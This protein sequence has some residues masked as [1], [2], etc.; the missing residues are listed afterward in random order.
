MKNMT[1][2]T[3]KQKQYSSPLYKIRKGKEKQPFKYKLPW[4]LLG[5]AIILAVTLRLVIPW[6]LAFPNEDWI[7]FGDVD[8]YYQMRVVDNLIANFPHLSEYDPYRTYPYQMHMADR[9]LFN[10]LIA[11]VAMILG[12]GNPSE[13]LVDLVGVFISPILFIF[14]IVLVFFIA[15]YL[16]NSWVAGISALMVGTLGGEI[17]GRS[18]LGAADHHTL[19]L[20]LSLLVIFL[21]VATLKHS[22]DTLKGQL[23]GVLAGLTLGFYYVAWSGALIVYM[24]IV[25]YSVTHIIYNYFKGL[26]SRDIML[27]STYP[28]LISLSI[29]MF[30]GSYSVYKLLM[31]IVCLI[32][33]VA[34]G[35][36]K[37]IK[38][39]WLYVATLI[40]AP[41]LFF[42]SF[43]IIKWYLV[44]QGLNTEFN[45]DLLIVRIHNYMED[46]AI[47]L[48]QNTRLDRLFIWDWPTVTEEE[49]PFLIVQGQ[50]SF[51]RVWSYFG[52]SFFIAVAMLVILLINAL[53]KGD[54]AKWFVVIWSLAMFMATLTMVR[55]AYYFAINVAIL[56]GWFCYEV[57]QLASPKLAGAKNALGRFII[58]GVVVVGVL[59]PNL[60][61]L[62]NMNKGNIATMRSGWHEAMLW[63]KENGEDPFGDKEFYYSLYDTYTEPKHSTMVWWDYGYWV[64]REG[65][66][67]ALA[68]PG[69]STRNKVAK[70]F[71]SDNATEIAEFMAQYKVKYIVVDYEITAHKF[72]ALPLLAKSEK[73][74]LNYY[75][76]FKVLKKVPDTYESKMIFYPD[77]Y[78]TLLNRLYYFNGKTIDPKKYPI[79]T[80]KNNE[81]I[82][83]TVFETENDAQKYLRESGGF[84]ASNNP[85]ISPIELPYIGN[86]KLVFESKQ[87]VAAT[88]TPLVKIFE[89]IEPDYSGCNCK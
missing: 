79:F 64:M 50:L 59:L 29:V 38:N 69:E 49:L 75:E 58:I 25:A 57:Y 39:K 14:V 24:I 2:P 23:F 85:S 55:F 13:R 9:P 46:I 8:C 86:F 22:M 12:G 18:M 42:A 44:S 43:G 83:V 28:M 51:A 66:Q 7:R 16:F 3:N 5:L 89:Y 61:S 70:C 37:I 6:D 62:Q 87:K 40:S 1:Y 48:G 80:A 32:P 19:E 47:F 81:L 63:L 76:P 15:L 74:I 77:Y 36:S 84:L 31:L 73:N 88:G 35:L 72:Y 41:I 53:K 54:K 17:F 56:T 60:S 82:S 30:I 26:D 20:L 68:N 27:C 11:G 34:W 33:I 52:I 21:F 71:L 45:T 78:K 67:V 65:R 4:I 10:Y